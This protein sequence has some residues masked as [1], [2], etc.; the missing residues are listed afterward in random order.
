MEK[1]IDF[2]LDRYNQLGAGLTKKDLTFQAAQCLRINTLKKTDLLRR[3]R[4]QG[5]VLEKISFLD[6]GYRI[7]KSPFSLGATPEFLLGYYYLQEA[8]AQVPVQVLD[9]QKGDVVL[10]CCAAPGGKTTQLAQYMNNTGRIISFEKKKHRLISVMT[11]LERCGVTNTIVFHADAAT[12]TSHAD[13]ILLDVPCSGNYALEKGWFEKR[14]SGIGKNTETQKALLTAA[15]RL[16]KKNGVIVYSTCSLEPEENEFII[17]WAIKNLHLTLQPTNLSVG[18]SS[19]TII[20]EKKLHP[21]IHLC[22]R[23]WPKKTD[24]Q[25]FFVAKLS[26]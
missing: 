9:P 23:F 18:T 13:K 6:Y 1:S 24:T 8:A 26:R 21:S 10:D 19:P 2:F 12:A 14:S 11:N 25:G 4:N 5:V 17:D 15:A 20:F 7:Q 3:L 16:L 22:R